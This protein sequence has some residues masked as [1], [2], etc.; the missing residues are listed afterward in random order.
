MS[1]DT[2]NPKLAQLA[3]TPAIGIS[4]SHQLGETQNVV[5]QAHV[6]A[7]CDNRELDEILDKMFRASQRQRAKSLLPEKRKTLE[8]LKTVH[9]RAA[10]DIVRLDMERKLADEAARALWAQTHRGDYKETPK[11]MQ[12]R[13]RIEADKKNA[14][15]TYKRYEEDIA[16][17]EQEI[18]DLEAQAGED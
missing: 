5:M 8:R 14:E 9:E 1:V 6:P 15:I 10:E 12:E 18:R 2:L 4:I 16:E 7:D 3:A 17:R 13:Q 11:T